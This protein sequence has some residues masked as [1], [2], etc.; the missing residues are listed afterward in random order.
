MLTKEQL[1]QLADEKI[2]EA[3][4]IFAEMEDDDTAH[5]NNCESDRIERLFERMQQRQT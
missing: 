4:A 3:E 5:K 2:K 1:D